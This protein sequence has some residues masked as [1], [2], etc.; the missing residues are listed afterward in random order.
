MMQCHVMREKARG[1]AHAQLTHGSCGRQKVLSYCWFDGPMIRKAE[2]A[3]CGYFVVEGLVAVAHVDIELRA[4][5][6]W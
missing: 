6:S 3:L 4:T 5:W 1:R 2:K